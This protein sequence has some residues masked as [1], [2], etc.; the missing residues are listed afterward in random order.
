MRARGTMIPLASPRAPAAPLGAALYESHYL[1]AA[2]PAGG[3]ALWLRFTALKRPGEPAHLTTWLTF[4]DA[5]GRGAPGAAG[6]RGRA[7]GRSRSSG[8]RDRA[9]GRSG[10]RA[11]AV[12]WRGRADDSG[13]GRV[14]WD[15]R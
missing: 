1:T 8:G 14:S 5:V 3:R 10:R 12:S 11:P 13:L 7:A 6:D 4:F 9:W 15:L 2:A